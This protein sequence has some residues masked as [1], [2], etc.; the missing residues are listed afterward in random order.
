M[1]KNQACYILIHQNK[2]VLGMANIELVL[3]TY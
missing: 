1:Q 2:F 3:Q